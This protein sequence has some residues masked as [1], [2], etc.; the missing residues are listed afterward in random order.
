MKILSMPVASSPYVPDYIYNAGV[1]WV[2]ITSYAYK[3][4]G[5][6]GDTFTGSYTINGQYLRIQN[7]VGSNKGYSSFITD[8]LDFTHIKQ[9]S[10]YRYGSSG[11]TGA[12]MCTINTVQDNYVPT[13][14]AVAISTNGST[15]ILDT[16]TLTGKHRFVIEIYLGSATTARLDL[17]TIAI[18]KG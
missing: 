1:V 15:Y 12:Y 7:T 11:A 17:G 10:L 16:S 13:T 5:Q 4:S 2:P 6:T 8:E 9:I 3:Q 14:P 18:V